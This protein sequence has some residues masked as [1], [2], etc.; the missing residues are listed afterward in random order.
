LASHSFRYDVA[1]SFLARDLAVAEDLAE[2]L[3]GL[4][5]FVYSRKKE[6]TLG[7]DGMDLFGR[8]FGSEARLTVILFRAGWGETPW[9]AYEE[10]HIK[11]RALASHMKSFMV[12]QLDKSEV[13]TWVPDS[14]LLTNIESETPDEIATIIA[15]RARQ[16]GAVIRRATVAEYVVQAKEK[17]TAELARQQRQESYQGMEEVCKEVKLLFAEIGRLVAEVKAADPEIDADFGANMGECAIS[18]GRFSTSVAWLQRFGNNLHDARLRVNDWESRVRVPNGPKETAGPGWKR[19]SH[20]APKVADNDAWVWRLAP[21][22]DDRREAALIFM[23]APSRKEYSTTDLADYLVR[24]H[25]RN[26]IGFESG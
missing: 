12:V 3:T 19:A 21:E 20:Y 5:P 23:G 6:E 15:F 26:A 14:H 18:S 9:T 4:E 11:D 1:F 13:P 25:F 17:A 10:A 2:R 22:Y 7:R 24:R 16:E 8:V